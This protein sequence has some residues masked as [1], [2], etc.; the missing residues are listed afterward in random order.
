MAKYRQHAPAGASN[1]TPTGE[2]RLVLPLPRVFNLQVPKDC[3]KL[4]DWMEKHLVGDIEE[5]IKLRTS[6]KEPGNYKK[7]QKLK[8][9]SLWMPKGAY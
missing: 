4:A 5:Q 9:D 2:K 1:P 8:E 3:E 7:I 6:I